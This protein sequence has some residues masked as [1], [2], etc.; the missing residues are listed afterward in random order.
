MV[1][2]NPNF[3]L[4]VEN[5]LFADISK[6]VADFTAAGGNGQRVIKMGIGDVTLP[7]ADAVIEA[8]HSAVSEMG[9][10]ETFQGYPPYDG[11]PFLKKAISD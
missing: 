8:M 11:Y 1:K 10:K 9:V 3:G 6:R 7:L 5:Y 4:L 2:T